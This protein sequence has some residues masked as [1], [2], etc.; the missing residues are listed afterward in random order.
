MFSSY[1][2]QLQQNKRESRDARIQLGLAESALEQARSEN[3]QLQH[4]LA[5]AH[6]QIENFKNEIAILNDSLVK[7][8]DS[9]S[10][11]QVEV[12]RANSQ[13]KMAQEQLDE[14]TARQEL[15][16][17]ELKQSLLQ[18]QSELKKG[19]VM[20]FLSVVAVVLM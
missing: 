10:S 19:M 6:Q 12:L 2:L 5:Q 7:L 20:L 3:S 18:S 1:F 15:E 17:A 4:E 8:E 9:N 11:A 16:I 13:A 14:T